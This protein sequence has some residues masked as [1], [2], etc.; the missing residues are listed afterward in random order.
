VLRLVAYRLIGELVTATVG[1]AIPLFVASK[2]LVGWEASL[3]IRPDGKGVRRHSETLPNHIRSIYPFSA[4]TVFPPLLSALSLI[5]SVLM[6]RR[7]AHLAAAPSMMNNDNRDFPGA[8]RATSCSPA[9]HDQKKL[10]D[11]S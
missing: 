9:V 11:D 7:D 6:L 8:N 3:I 1:A 4:S 5:Y 2:D 10:C